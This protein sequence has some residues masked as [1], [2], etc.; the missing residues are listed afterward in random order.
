MKRLF[1]M[2]LMLVSGFCR[3]DSIDLDGIT[4]KELAAL[5]YGEILRVQYVVDQSVID[6]AD[7]VRVHLNGEPAVLSKSIRQIFSDAGIEVRERGGVTFLTTA[8]AG[9]EP[10]KE[11]S[12]Y[13]PKWRSVSYLQSIV[14]KIIP[15]VTEASASVPVT[16]LQAS[17]QKPVVKDSSS[18]APKTAQTS[19]TVSRG[20]SSSEAGVDV[21]LLEGRLRDVEKAQKLLESLDVPG[22]E[23]LVKA[24]VYEVTTEKT[25]R[26]AIKVAA[27][28]LS[29]KIGV[30]LGEA[31]AGNWSAVLKTGGISVIMDALSKDSRFKVVTSPSLRVI[32]GASSSLTVGS[33]T[34][35]LGQATLDR[36]GNPVQSVDYKSSGVILNL[37]PEIRESAIDLRINQQI[38]NFIQTTTGVNNSPTL[39]KREMETTVS[40]R[41]DDV[42]VI[43]GLDEEKTTDSRTGLSFLPDWFSG[44]GSTNNKTEILLI[45]EAKR[46]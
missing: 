6:K 34:P 20:F 8:K 16:G 44:R 3:A 37:K 2:F 30:S 35:V 5:L 17:E 15:G 36:N 46:I 14:N 24:V 32:D 22:K 42:I 33:D 1:I 26:S 4:V 21:V 25:D 28:L 43:G 18:S 31:T 9:A 45:L 12:I 27:D 23:V 39:V 38:S 41:D 10:E 29:G 13:R 7:T 11:F 40:I 19:Q